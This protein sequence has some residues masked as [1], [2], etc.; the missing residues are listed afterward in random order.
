MQDQIA[1]IFARDPT[2]RKGPV[3]WNL[4][5]APLAAPLIRWMELAWDGLRRWPYSSADVA[6]ALATVVEY[7]MLVHRQSTARH[8]IV[9]ARQFAERCLGGE[10][11]AVEIGMEDGS[12][13]RGFVNSDLFWQAVRPDFGN[14]LTDDWRPQITSVRHV[15][16]AASNPKRA[17]VFDRLQSLFCTQIVPTQTV[18]RDE[19]SG[20]ARL[21]NLARA[22]S[23]GLP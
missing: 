15:L 18:L 21:Y 12:Y 6:Q 19:T 9:L 5:D 1:A 14:F 3:K 17:L 20:M 7:G 11:E 8:D 22:I 16:Q 13:T 4:L 23:I 2:L 10:T